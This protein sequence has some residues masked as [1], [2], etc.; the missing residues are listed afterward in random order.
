LFKI[1]LFL[2]KPE[3]LFDLVRFWECK[4]KHAVNI[5]PWA[6]LKTVGPFSR[7]L[8]KSGRPIQGSG[9]KTRAYKA[10]IAGVVGPTSEVGDQSLWSHRHILTPSTFLHFLGSYKFIPFLISFSQE[11]TQLT[12]DPLSLEKWYA[13]VSV[14]P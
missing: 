7:E 3:D 4:G 9:P 6:I 8:W 1:Y 14:T 10:V 5:M 11:N 13:H 12:I 2:I